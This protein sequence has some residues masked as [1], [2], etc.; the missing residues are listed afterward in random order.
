M[1]YDLH[2]PFLRFADCLATAHARLGTVR[3]SAA[4]RSLLSPLRPCFHGRDLHPLVDVGFAWRTLGT[5]HTTR[6]VLDQASCGA[7]IDSQALARSGL[8]V[9]SIIDFV[10]PAPPNVSATPINLDVRRHH[11]ERDHRPRMSGG[12]PLRL[13]CNALPLAFFSSRARRPIDLGR[14]TCPT[15]SRGQPPA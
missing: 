9:P 8:W 6:A 11:T 1:H 7:V 12:V 3:S 14:A 2:T 15:R 5:L 13:R 10:V 4:H